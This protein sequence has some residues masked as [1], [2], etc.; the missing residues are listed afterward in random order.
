[1]KEEPTVHTR[2]PQF[3]LAVTLTI[4]VPIR[5]ASVEVVTEHAVVI[6]EASPVFYIV[7]MI[8][9]AELL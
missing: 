2:V 5:L 3:M 4:Y 6:A 1:M 9:P 8:V 7:H